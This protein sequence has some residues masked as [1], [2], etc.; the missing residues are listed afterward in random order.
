MS[1]GNECDCPML[2]IQGSLQRLNCTRPIYC[3]IQFSYKS[4]L[5]RF[6]QSRNVGSSFKNW[7]NNLIPLASS[8]SSFPSGKMKDVWAGRELAQC[9]GELK[10]RRKVPKPQSFCLWKTLLPF[11]HFQVLFPNW[12]V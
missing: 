12:Y 7:Q 9:V 8:L 11:C 1:D 4:M 5:V 6:R 3:S 2:T 10:P